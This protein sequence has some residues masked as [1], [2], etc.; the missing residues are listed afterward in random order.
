MDYNLNMDLPSISIITPT[1]NHI[2][3]IRDTIESVLDQNY[4]DLEYLV[5]DGGSIDG[6][7]DLLK[8][9]GDQI[10]W[11]SEKD[12]GQSD[13]INKGLKMARG[14]IVGF[15]NS[16]DLYLPGALEKVGKYFARFP[17]KIWVTGKCRTINIRG[18]EINK[19][20]TMY[21]NFWLKFNSTKI[22]YI[23]NYISQPSTFW[24]REA[25][26][27][28][29]FLDDKLYFTM[30]YDYWLKLANIKKPGVIKE[31]LSLFRLYPT[32]K[33]GGTVKDQF[34]EEL[35]VASKSAPSNA[36]I[37]L[38]KFHNKIIAALY[39]RLRGI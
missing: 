31:Y 2:D 8:S 5:I 28:I 10:K 33:S 25:I 23:L 30:D 20:V 14:E 24:R 17:A 11:I 26:D 16:D 39:S 7:V 34:E 29:G 35:S 15:I 19:L 21:K 12:D 37:K 18:D 9:Y 27:Q 4:P 36:L 38:H 32:S 6:T 1:F 13:A 22:L 3:F